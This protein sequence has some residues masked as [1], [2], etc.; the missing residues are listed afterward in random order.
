MVFV[1]LI[2]IG[3]IS[4]T[5]LSVELMPNA[6]YG[7]VTI[8][9]NV[10]GGMPPEDIE[11]LVTRPVEEAVSPVKHLNHIIST[12]KKESSTVMLTFEPGT[13]MK[14][15]ALE[16]REKIGQIRNK[17]PEE[18]EKPVIERYDEADFP[19]MILA[20]TGTGYTPEMLRKIAEKRMKE[21]LSRINGVANVEVRGGR[22]RKILVEIDQARLQAYNLPIKKV[23]ATLNL[24]NLNLLTGSID[25]RKYRYL[26]RT[27]GEFRNVKEIKKLGIMVTPRGSIIRLEDIADVKDSYL[28]P[29]A[30]ARLNTRP[31]TA[32]YIHKESTANTVRVSKAIKKELEKI[33]LNLPREVNIVTVSDQAVFIKQSIKT[34]WTS[35]LFGAFLAGAILFLFLKDIKHIFVIV[36]VIPISV[37]L[38]FSLMYFRKITLNVMTLSGL[39]LGIGMLLDNSIVVLENIFKH[40]TKLARENDQSI[41]EGIE[42]QPGQKEIPVKATREVILPIVAGTITTLVVFLP[43]V[44]INKQVEILYSGLA[45]TVTFSLVASLFV[46]LTLVPLLSSRIPLHPARKGLVHKGWGSKIF[47]LLRKRNDRENY[48]EEEVESKAPS[49]FSNGVYGENKQDLSPE[50]K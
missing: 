2:I 3:G 14:F 12:S 50:E 39:A 5:R 4:L 47:G 19:I 30:Y 18:I 42:S 6:S 34:V 33:K 49:E 20:L 48:G 11:S 15:A 9:I 32:L 41:P 45:L 17:L 27:M 24:S 23:I 26:V 10:R 21:Q 29:E 1:G 43:I 13:N 36:A 7:I 8:K 38:A 37:M 28:E 25:K 46:A 16:V 40:K 44:F 22:E 35:L 31:V